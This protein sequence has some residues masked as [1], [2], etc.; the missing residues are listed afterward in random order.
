LKI[1]DDAI[2]SELIDR[3]AGMYVLF[4]NN[5]WRFLLITLDDTSESILPSGEIDPTLLISA[6]TSIE[7]LVAKW[8]M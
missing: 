8:S 2:L 6:N 1:F 3:Y 4:K 5:G 7:T